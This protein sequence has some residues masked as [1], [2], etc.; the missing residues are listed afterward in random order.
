MREECVC[1]SCGRAVDPGD[2]F[3]SAC[4]ARLGEPPGSGEERKRVSVVVVDLVGYAGLSESLDPEDT[5]L[6]LEDYWRGV[7][8]EVERYGGT[9]E[10]FIGDAV[11][12][13]FGA[14]AAHEDD[15]ERAVRAALAIRERSRE[16]TQPDVRIAVA[17]GIALVRLDSRPEAGEALVV[18]DVVTTAARLQTK[19]PPD[20]VL[21]DLATRA[22]TREVV[23]F[24][25][26]PPVE[27]KG[28]REPVSAWLVVGLRGDAARRTSATRFVGRRHE[29][30]LLRTVLAR[31]EA[32]SNV[33][34]VTVVGEPGIGKT[35]L[36]RELTP[37][38][39]DRWEARALPYGE[40][41]AFSP[42][43]ELV[44]R[45]A[46]I[47]PGD[48]AEASERLSA[49]LRELLADE[50][51][52]RLVEPHVRRLV[53]LDA[54]PATAP[55]ESF[56]AWRRLIAAAAVRRPLV[57]VLE[58][59]HWAD[60][61][62]LD[63]LEHLVEWAGP[64]PL[65]V[66]CTARPDLL[67][68]R[69]GWGG[70]APN[71]LTLSLGPLSDE[72]T[73][74]L[75]AD[76]LGHEPPDPER[77]ALL[78][79]AGGNPLYAEQLARMLGESRDPAEAV[80]ETVHAVIAARIDR[81]PA[82]AKRLL[83]DAAVVGLS[84]PAA[85]LAALV[86]QTEAELESGLHELERLE[87]VGRDRAG[88]GAWSFRHRLVREVAYEQ[89]PRSARA[90]K[91][92][93]VARLLEE[94][95][96]PGE[97]AEL[98]AHHYARARE[99]ALAAGR[100]RDDLDG[101]ART[102][103]L[104]AGGRSLDLGAFSSAARLYAQ[105]LELYPA[106]EPGRARHLLRYAHALW[107]AETSGEA[108]AL[109]ALDG[110]VAAG[111][112]EAAAEAEALLTEMRW[113]RGDRAGASEHLEHAVSLVSG[114]PASRA[115]AL[116][117]SRLARSQ[118]L[119]AE[120]EDAVAN[121]RE[122]LALAEE[123][124]LV[125]LQAQA[126]NSI[127]SARYRSGDVGGL[128]D[129][130]RAIALAG[131]TCA[132]IV[133]YNNLGAILLES[134]ERR[135]SREVLDRGRALA[136]QLGD[137]L[138]LEWFDGEEVSRLFGEDRWDE[139]LEAAERWLA[140]PHQASYATIGVLAGRSLMLHARG[141]RAA[142]LESLARAETAA[143]AAADPQTLGPTL[144]EAAFVL[145]EEG[146]TADAHARAEEALELC[147]QTGGVPPLSAFE[148]AV[149]CS[150]C[151]L[152]RRLAGMLDAG[153]VPSRWIEAA[154]RYVAGELREALELLEA[155]DAHWPAAYARRRL[156]EAGEPEAAEAL[157]YYRAV[158]AVRYAR[159]CEE[160]LG[161]DLAGI[162][163]TRRAD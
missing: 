48:G 104:R 65:L 9:V 93:L 136:E 31:A 35:R 125:E 103:L 61:A 44:R 144:A 116:V 4:G 60:D 84:F 45:R 139:A 20:E 47:A 19:A 130:E 49:L 163:D 83:L 120:H 32:G 96:P 53:G 121:G 3:C 10:K 36:V 38:R 101:S 150:G 25:R 90:R 108:V 88:A 78:G 95:R 21:V 89:I 112:A 52:R 153:R 134:G 86:P 76:V 72:E 159:R 37:G 63:F 119:A 34:L 70:G 22:A 66:L 137:R 110:L 26:V 58:D 41:G 97:A 113:Y 126:L 157:A 62:L 151:G 142:A 149:A 71:S 158:G 138:L 43:A 55:L 135:R 143:R 98:V 94:R 133:A 11:V 54:Q 16:H 146:R 6:L 117:L 155:V 105:A 64:V 67:R 17:T 59:A 106:H 1:R 132:G 15:A 154:R 99:E 111:D 68:R 28:K 13:V 5:R 2:R 92:E 24:R 18:G 46:G 75:V 82:T 152:G 73:A 162:G 127:G 51:E 91:H 39:A 131:G 129:L 40:G 30:T 115:K 128:D 42:L 81:L 140:S 7:R 69:P 100:P 160:L 57:L 114:R 56:A 156:A 23:E 122:A 109:E 12:G 148:L 80:P 79:R 27:A 33:E 102:A 29:L 50:D 141:E 77:E 87:L 14:P 145:L 107:H 123:L 85:L 118:M 161:G 8:D 74:R 147:E 124:G